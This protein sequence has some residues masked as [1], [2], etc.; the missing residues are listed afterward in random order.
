MPARFAKMAIRCTSKSNSSET[1]TAR[2]CL[3]R[4]GAIQLF[5]S[6]PERLKNEIGRPASSYRTPSMPATTCLPGGKAATGWRG[7]HH[8]P[9]AIELRVRGIRQTDCEISS[10][11]VKE[12]GFNYHKKARHRHPT[13]QAE[14]ISQILPQVMVCK[15]QRSKELA[16]KKNV[17]FSQ[18]LP[19][20]SR[21][22]G[23]H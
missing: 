23:L 18:T 22:A 20:M 17:L 7:T 6:A 5:F 11:L 16:P 3:C 21:I 8:G 10:S 12:G 15:V 4:R 19:N 1:F 9:A 14:A 13:R 2:L